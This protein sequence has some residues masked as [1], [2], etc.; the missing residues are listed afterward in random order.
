MMTEQETTLREALQAAYPAAEPS[1]ALRQRVSAL[2][3]ET[4]P[5]RIQTIN[6]RR[7]NALRF[8]GAGA[9]VLLILILSLLPRLNAVLALTRM[10]NSLR[11]VR[12]VHSVTWRVLPDGRRVKGHEQWYQ[13]G[14]W[15]VEDDEGRRIQ[16]CAGGKRWVYASGENTVTLERATSPIGYQGITGFSVAASVQDAVAAGVLMKV[17]VLGQAK[18][19]GRSV[20]WIQMS[21][22]KYPDARSKIAVDDATDL[23]VQGETEVRVQG[24][25]TLDSVGTSEYDAPLAAPLFTPNFP[26]TARLI[27]VEAGREIWRKK[28][29]VGI[30]TQLRGDTTDIITYEKRNGVIYPKQRPI[31]EPR[32]VVVRDFQV[33]ANG[34]VFLLFTGNTPVGREPL[35]AAELTDEYGTQYIAPAAQ[36]DQT[37]YMDFIATCFDQDEKNPSGMKFDGYLFNN[38]AL[39]AYWWVPL[40]PCAPGKPHHFTLTLH[41]DFNDGK[42][43]F[44]LTVEK[45]EPTI[46]P[47]YMPYTARPLFN[48]WVITHQEALTRAKYYHDEA[49]D[50]PQAL[51]WYQKA[52][53]ID[54]EEDRR[55]G[56]HLY[57]EIEWFAIYQIQMKMGQTEEAKAALLRANQD[58]VY[59]GSLRDAIRAEMQKLGLNP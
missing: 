25:W 9:T 6:R 15:R 23:P 42:S 50:L 1:D 54:Q 10:A 52:I 53:A 8:L 47:E 56:G 26:K 22:N 27:D 39:E 36:T 49:H 59:A 5:A 28:L 35:R 2:A 58:A 17:E 29:A 7:R 45:P 30:A 13:A 57:E 51:A 16:I 55:A 4:L 20:Q 31:R 11:D 21:D 44:S 46:V 18:L 38:E 43:V 32:R 37:G 19:N 33:N 3:A 41:Q 12:S 14:N 24:R 34:D 48:A 40:Q